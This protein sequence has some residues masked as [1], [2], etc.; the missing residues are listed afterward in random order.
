MPGIELKAS[1]MCS[2]VEPH[3]QLGI[4]KNKYELKIVYFYKLENES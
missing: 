2:T 4:I 1:D 3:A